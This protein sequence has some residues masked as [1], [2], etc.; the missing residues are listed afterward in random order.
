[1]FLVTFREGGKSRIGVLDRVRGEI[2]DLSRAAS[3][4]PQDMPSFIALGESGL[5]EARRAVTSGAG[6]LPQSQVLLVAPIPRPARNIFCVGKN[7]REHT[8]ELQRESSTIMANEEIP[9]APII[10]TKATSAVIGQGEPIPAWLDSTHTTDYEGELAVVIGI[11]G[12]GIA[13]SEAMRYVYG[14]T[15]IN[16]VTARVMQGRHQQWFLSKSLDGFCPMGP[17]LATVE[18][19]PEVGQLRVQTHVNSELRQNTPV[20]DMIFDIPILIETLSRTM[21][22][23]PGDIISTGTPAGVGMGFKPPKYL[24]KGD[25]VAITIEPIGTLENPVA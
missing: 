2:I 10:F 16:D 13:R 9:D 14:Y 3:G 24:Q 12:R 4:L 23:T 11:G 5:V 21:T 8:Q 6:R 25:R 18:E 20:A 17:V 1:M 15:I 22:L 7:Y 19:V